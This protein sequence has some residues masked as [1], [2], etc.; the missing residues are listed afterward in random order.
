[1]INEYCRDISSKCRILDKETLAKLGALSSEGDG[2]AK[3]RIILSCLPLVVRLARN[4]RKNNKHIEIEDMVQEGN[5]ALIKAVEKWDPLK[6]S[7]T[8]VVTRYVTNALTDMITDSKYRIRHPH[9]LPRSAMIQL[10]KIMNTKSKDVEEISKLTGIPIRTIKSIL[11]S[12]R[13]GSRRVSFRTAKYRKIPEKDVAENTQKPCSAD[14]IGLA[15][16][17]LTGDRK[18]IFYRWAGLNRKRQGPSKIS[19]SLGKSE[20][21]VY[22]NIYSAKRTLAKHAGE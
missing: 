16:L 2:N 12:N 15:D 13:L 4:F 6:A 19:I 18:E 3:E 21:Y 22:D 10:R 7:I 9:S 11:S 5:I 17:H 14:L 20:Q 8:T 1:M